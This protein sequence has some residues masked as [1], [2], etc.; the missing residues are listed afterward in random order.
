LRKLFKLSLHEQGEVTRGV[1]YEGVFRAEHA[2]QGL[3]E[4]V[5]MVEM[6]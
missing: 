2:E 1:D 6:G 4:L 3:C 5:V